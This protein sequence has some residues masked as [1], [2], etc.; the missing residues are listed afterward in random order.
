MNIA[1]VGS[2]GVGVTMRTAR[3]P[4]PG[5]T[6]SGG[7]LSTGH[8]GKGSNQAVA[9][10]RLGARVS[11]LT[12]VGDDAAASSAIELWED[13]GIDASG[14]VRI[15]GAATMTGIILLESSAEN[16]IIIAPGALD[17]LSAADVAA[18]EADIAAADALI[19]CLEIPLDAAREALRIA[20]GAGILTVLNPAP[21][22]EIPAEMLRDVDILTPNLTE[23]QVLTGDH[24]ASAPELVERLQELTGSRV[25]L[26]M[27]DQGS[28]VADDSGVHRIDPVTPEHVV[29]TTGA[30]DSFTAAITVAVLEGDSLHAAA[31]RAASV[32]AHVVARHEVIPALPHRSELD[33]DLWPPLPPT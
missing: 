14:V 3:V 24:A 31:A 28:L 25:V 21:A 32:G 16:R 15:P 4:D 6:I 27:G 5:E 26:T 9:A 1:V 22:R 19:V 33:Q 10:S 8:G 23:A 12:A 29:D 11:F 7:E 30:G 20:R 17:S 18:R 2:Y 13:E